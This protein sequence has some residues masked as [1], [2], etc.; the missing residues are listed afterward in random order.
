[1]MGTRGGGMG[2]KNA[3]GRPLGSKNKGWDAPGRGQGYSVPVLKRAHAVIV[4]WKTQPSYF[5]HIYQKY[6]LI[7]NE[8][9]RDLERA[10]Q[11]AIFVNERKA[12]FERNN[13]RTE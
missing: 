9:N 3:K 1:M 2:N 5:R 13:R 6:I 4:P 12:N 8:A 10:L 11:E 7:A